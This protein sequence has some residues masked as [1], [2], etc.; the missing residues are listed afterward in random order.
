[1]T[2]LHSWQQHDWKR[3]CQ[4]HTQARIPQALLIHG[5]NGLGKHLLAR[6]F[7]ASLLCAS[8]QTDHLACGNCKP[9]QLFQADTHPD[10]YKLNPEEPGK[11]INVDAIRHLIGELS[12][13]PQ[14]PQYRVI[15][16]NLAE[17]M[18]L[19][20]QNAFLKCLEEPA[21]RS[22]ILLISERPAKLPATIAS[23]CQQFAVSTPPKADTLA[24]L[25]TQNPQSQATLALQLAQ[26]APINA[27]AYCDGQQFK[28]RQDCFQAWLAVSNRQ[29]SPTHVAEN[30]QKLPDAQLLA[31]LLSWLN[32]LA[33]CH[34]QAE[35]KQLQNVDLQQALQVLAQRLELNNVF[36]HYDL[37]LDRYQLLDTTIN[38]QLMFEE[39]LIH[40]LAI[41]RSTQHVRPNT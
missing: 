35:D 2:D 20:A 24:W 22:V 11:A 38:K 41:N 29:L 4:Y 9:C 25:A 1:M 19:K 17:Q 6:Q 32:D 31:W 15:I 34:Y 21:E 14:Y 12:L 7:A 10:F 26:G 16:I 30:W 5:R 23:R 40:W 39:I 13:K 3:L 8:P 28:Q 18:N 27:L 37:I 36:K 33:K